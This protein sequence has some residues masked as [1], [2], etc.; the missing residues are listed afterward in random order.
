MLLV[1]SANKGVLLV[2][3]ELVDD[4][5]L[6]ADLAVCAKSGVETVDSLPPLLLE[7]LA[8][9][10]NFCRVLLQLY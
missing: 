1:E 2:E 3:E 6:G 9:G 8:F 10:L 7:E 4:V 5:V